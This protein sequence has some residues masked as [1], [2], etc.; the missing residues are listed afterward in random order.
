[1]VGSFL[2]ANL[3]TLQV[4]ISRV[5]LD[6]P[7]SALYG[8]IHGSTHTKPWDRMFQYSWYFSS[9]MLKWTCLIFACYIWFI[10][11]SSIMLWHLVNFCVSVGNKYFSCT[12]VL[13]EEHK[14]DHYFPTVL[15]LHLQVRVKVISILPSLQWHYF[16]NDWSEW[17]KA[18][19]RMRSTSLNPFLPEL[20]A[21][22]F[23]ESDE[24]L[25]GCH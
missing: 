14:M 6:I 10:S 11:H 20:N 5:Q 13:N 21:R 16:T 8:T 17:H 15:G 3:T 23:S 4:R 9:F 12:A 24:I 25:Y 18:Q 1:M 22:G 7:L 2:S 19:H